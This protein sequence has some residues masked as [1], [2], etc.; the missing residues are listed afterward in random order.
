[1]ETRCG[2]AAGL[3]ATSADPWRREI[4]EDQRRSVMSIP[5][6]AR[7]RSTRRDTVRKAR[8]MARAGP[9][10]T[11]PWPR[12]FSIGYIGRSGRR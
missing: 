7:S 3:D 12:R 5:W 11:L 1:M 9:R 10:R 2:K 4:G 8:A 6:W